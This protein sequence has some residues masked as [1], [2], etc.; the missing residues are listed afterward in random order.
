[1]LGY[2]INLD[3]KFLLSQE[4]EEDTF[5][6]KLMTN[7][8]ADYKENRMNENTYLKRFPHNNGMRGNSFPR[9]LRVQAI[10]KH[11]FLY[12]RILRSEQPSDFLYKRFLKRDS[13]NLNSELREAPSQ[14]L[15]GGGQAWQD[16]FEPRCWSD[17]ANQLKYR[18]LF[19]IE[20]EK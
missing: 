13:W 18:L 20:W 1:M 7:D 17:G 8:V 11:D 2:G 5:K 10:R 16:V 6:P 3:N 4:G 14:Y 12:K 9:S 15:P 19:S